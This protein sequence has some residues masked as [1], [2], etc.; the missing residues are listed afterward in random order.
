MVESINKKPEGQNTVIIKPIEKPT[1]KPKPKPPSVSTG[2]SVLHCDV[3]ELES[4]FG[5]HFGLVINRS[6]P[7]LNF[8]LL[9]TV[10]CP[11]VKS[12]RFQTR[13]QIRH[14]STQKL[15]MVQF[16]K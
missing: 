13:E 7:Y 12:Q 14:V 4:K 2:S 6:Y 11:R 16:A 9:A 10:N 3:A 1:Q 5:L 8:P 15:S